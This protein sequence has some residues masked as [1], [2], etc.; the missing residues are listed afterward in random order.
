MHIAEAQTAL[1]I[2][3]FAV[4]FFQGV[5]YFNDDIFFT[6]GGGGSLPGWLVG[7]TNCTAAELLVANNNNQNND[8]NSV[9][10]VFISKQNTSMLTFSEQV[11]PFQA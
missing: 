7:S 3:R 11:F 2:F 5:N 10:T 4:F 6:N 1:D 8:D 9:I